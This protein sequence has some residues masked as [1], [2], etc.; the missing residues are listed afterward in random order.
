MTALLVCLLTGP[1]LAAP[2]PAS[3]DY[4]IVFRYRPSGPT[5]PGDYESEVTVYERQKGG[6]EKLIGTYRGSIFP[7]D[8]KTRGRLKD[9]R[10]ELALGLHRRSKDGKALTPTKADLVVKSVGWLRPAL[11]VNHDGPVPVLSDN[12]KKKT[13]T[14]IH[15]HNGGTKRRGSEGC[16]TLPPTDWPRFIRPFLARYP[17]LADWHGPRY[18]GRTIGV[19][20]VRPR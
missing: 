12:P 1:V 5:A 18:I 6:G 7:D 9:G 2:L 3:P 20:E 8:M 15:V 14:Y 13:S 4:R 11:I 16:L 17:N 10:Y 19:L